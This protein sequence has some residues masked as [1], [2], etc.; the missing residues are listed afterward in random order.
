MDPHIS[1][2]SCNNSSAVQQ[3]E[4]DMDIRKGPWTAEE[5]LILTNYITI[6]GEGRWNA[7]ARCAGLKRTGKSCRLRWLNYLRP[8]VRRGN[9]SLQEQL[10]ILELHTRWGNRWSKIAQF[11]PGRTDNEIKNYW[12]TRVQKQAKQLKCDVNS[13][14]FR[15]TMRCVWIP[16]LLERIRAESESSAGGLPNS[17]S[18]ASTTS[19]VSDDRYDDLLQVSPGGAGCEFGYGQVVSGTSS[20]SSEAQVSP[21]SGLVE[22]YS[23]PGCNYQQ[24][25]A[26]NGQGYCPELN[27]SDLQVSEQWV[28]G[29]DESL[30]E[31]M[32]SD[33]D[34]W[35]LQ[36]QLNLN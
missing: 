4:D 28:G 11:L 34:I 23:F 22:S 31:N 35:F 21:D 29:G 27:G 3:A 25:S 13:Q 19:E 20:E 30:V 1:V 8:D 7:L 2:G 18:P 6:Y 24:D 33:E 17:S 16:R 10:L 32:W 12:R 26:Q 14:Q 9:I 36:Q 15:D 5:D